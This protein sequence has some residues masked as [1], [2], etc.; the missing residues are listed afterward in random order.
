[1]TPAA[2]IPGARPAQ[3]GERAL[4]EQARAAAA[5]AH[6][7]YSGL[8]VGAVA[9]GEGG[10]AFVGVNVENSSHPVGLCAERVALGALVSSGQRWIASIAV[11]A[12]DRRDLLPCGACLQALSEFG[13]PDV[14]AVVD[15]AATVVP[16]AALLP[17]PFQHH[18]EPS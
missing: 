12:G 16:F 11:A 4:L 8:R 17:A 7:P 1:V 10:E 13:A 2:H 18:K 15:G 3:A 5:R 14:I 6:A 9:V